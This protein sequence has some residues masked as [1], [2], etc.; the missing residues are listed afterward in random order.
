MDTSKYGVTDL[1]SL[2]IQS[3]QPKEKNFGS[4]KGVLQLA[5]LTQDQAVSLGE[6]LLQ[7]EALNTTL[8]NTNNDTRGILIFMSNDTIDEHGVITR[9]GNIAIWDGTDWQQ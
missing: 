6:T 9:D 5:I 1:T 4:L 8:D 3:L 7:I 2:T